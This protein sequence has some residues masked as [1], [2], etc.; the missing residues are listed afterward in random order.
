MRIRCEW[1]L[2]V[3]AGVLLAL[4]GCGDD[5]GGGSHATPTAPAASTA[6]ATAPALPTATA[7][8]PAVPTATPSAGGRDGHAGGGP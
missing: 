3:V 6:T 5:D 2:G 1:R 8:V 4:V 7:T